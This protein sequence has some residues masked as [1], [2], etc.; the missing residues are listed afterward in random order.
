MTPTILFDIDGTLLSFHGIGRKA[1]QQ[2]MEEVWGIPRALEGISF[3]GST[4]GL[5]AREV[6]G[7]RPR[8]AMWARY[9]DNLERMVGAMAAPDP[10]AG[11]AALLDELGRRG[12][13]LGLL[14]GNLRGGAIIKLRAV[15][16]LEH[17]DLAISGFAEDGDPRDEVAA[18]A[19]RRCDGAPVVVVGD[20]VADVTCARHIGAR[21]LAVLTGVHGE[22]ELSAAGPDL[23]VNDLTATEALAAWLLGQP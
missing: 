8:E 4:D 20:T 15:G 2:A 11:C 9:L 17:F 5:V 23:I 21:V 22:A 10:H 14:T 3:A 19:R 16:L 1:M 12:A 6:G 7:A 13:R 18:A